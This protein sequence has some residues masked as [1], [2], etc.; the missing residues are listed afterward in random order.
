MIIAGLVFS[1]R[2][3]YQLSQDKNSY[4]LPDWYLSLK[5]IIFNDIKINKFQ[6]KLRDTTKKDDSKKTKTKKPKRGDG[7]KKNPTKKKGE[8]SDPTA[9]VSNTTLESSSSIIHLTEEASG[10]GILLG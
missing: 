6:E 1:L 2:A 8:S 3:I 4:L 5:A 7:T 10:A 9:T